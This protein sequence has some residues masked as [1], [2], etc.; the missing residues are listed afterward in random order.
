M[1]VVEEGA[2]FFVTGEGSC[3]KLF[4]PITHGPPR[5]TFQPLMLR[6]EQEEPECLLS[7][8][9][10]RCRIC[11]AVKFERAPDGGGAVNLRLANTRNSYLANC[12]SGQSL[13]TR[14]GLLTVLHASQSMAALRRWRYMS[15][16]HSRRTLV[17]SWEA[18]STPRRP[19]RASTRSRK[20]GCHRL[21]PGAQS[22]ETGR[23]T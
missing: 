9:S 11:R 22:L 13:L 18:Y 8:A 12:K 19:G 21:M 5:M 1:K 4:F 17:F 10:E 14:M 6:K 7:R 16:W 3:E 23:L 20:R 15:F 2:E